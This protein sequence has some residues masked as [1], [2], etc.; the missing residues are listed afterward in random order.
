MKLGIPKR[1]RKLSNRSGK[2][3]CDICGSQEILECHHING[4]DKPNK[5]HP[6]NLTNICSNCHTRIHNNVIQIEG[7]MST[8]EGKKLMWNSI[9][10]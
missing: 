7:W 10:N 1:I 3:Y 8:T 9:N 6:F 4:R 5:N 2:F